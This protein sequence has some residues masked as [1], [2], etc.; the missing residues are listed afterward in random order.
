MKTNYLRKKIS[1]ESGQVLILGAI[2]SVVLAVASYMVLNIG[3][4]AS[5]KVSLQNTADAAALAGAQVQA[6][7]V[8]T[9]AWMNQAMGTI[10]FYMATHSANV[11]MAAT[12]MNFVHHMYNNRDADYDN[13]YN[14]SKNP[15]MYSS[16]GIEMSNGNGV[17]ETL[18]ENE[19][20]D[21]YKK[22]YL[23]AYTWIPRG[24]IWL[25]MMG[26]VQRGISYITPLMVEKEVFLAIQGKAERAAIFP[27]FKMYTDVANNF[28][29]TVKKVFENFSAQGIKTGWEFFGTP[30]DLSLTI[31]RDDVDANV[32]GNYDTNALTND[33]EIWSQHLRYRLRP[34]DP[35][36]WLNIDS[37]GKMPVPN[38]KISRYHLTSN[39][40]GWEDAYIQY[41]PD[42]VMVITGPNGVI[43]ITQ[44]PDGSTTIVDGSNPPL[45]YR[46]VGNTIETLGP[47]GWSSMGEID[48]SV[49][50]VSVRA[51]TD[52]SINLGPVTIVDP[53]TYHIG[54]TTI[55]VNEDDVR[56]STHIGRVWVRTES[57][58]AIISDLSTKTTDEKWRRRN[59]A[60]WT[61]TLHD[62]GGDTVRHRL[63]II[64]SDSDW[65]YEL[66]ETG[67]YV[68]EE[69]NYPHM[70][71]GRMTHKIGANF[72]MDR[73]G[74]AEEDKRW[75]ILDK[76]LTVSR[77]EYSNT[78][79]GFGQ[80]Y[81]SGP[82]EFDAS[83]DVRDIKLESFHIVAQCWN[84][85]CI[86]SGQ[87]G[88]MVYEYES[89]DDT[90]V[91]LP[92]ANNV[93]FTTL[94]M[95]R[96]CYDNQRTRN[97]DRRYYKFGEA[98]SGGSIWYPDSV[99]T[100]SGTTSLGTM[101]NNSYGRIVLWTDYDGNP[102]KGAVDYWKRTDSK[103]NSKSTDSTTAPD[104]RIEPQ[105]LFYSVIDEEHFLPKYIRDSISGSPSAS[106][107]KAALDSIGAGGIGWDM[108]H[109]QDG[110][111][112]I[113]MYPSDALENARDIASWLHDPDHGS[114][115]VVVKPLIRLDIT[116]PPPL[117]LSEDYFKFGVNVAVT[118]DKFDESKETKMLGVIKNTDGKNETLHGI[119]K[120]SW[121]MI[122]I[123]SART[124]F[125]YDGDGEGAYVFNPGDID[126]AQDIS[127][128]TDYAEF[129]NN[130][131]LGLDGSIEFAYDDSVSF[132]EATEYR[133]RRQFFIKRHS[134]NL[135]NSDWIAKLVPIKF[136]V[137]KED[138]DLSESDN[139]D[140]PAR[141]VYYNLM[142]TEWRETYVKT[143]G[144]KP[145]EGMTLGKKGP[146][147][148][149]NDEDIEAVI[150]H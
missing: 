96:I 82:I 139:F 111:T 42:G 128:A 134:D 131:N 19:I 1:S 136:T 86:K 60:H 110:K 132:E 36:T 116:A 33:P 4:V 18:S 105:V 14:L 149:T 145:P 109:N 147:L 29:L 67:G 46:R 117:V 16:T 73:H 125:W 23:D 5:E 62:Q 137:K 50:G 20:V 97:R 24:E 26:K 138:L 10:Y 124:A 142:R 35:E 83:N 141:Y 150:T 126:W 89:I 58:E 84:E 119:D 121:G 44:N 21:Q 122:A 108:D 148:S 72:I 71:N 133:I 114:S 13:A 17:S 25:W 135:Y 34:E 140:T 39:I 66:R 32:P 59:G 28:D 104:P 115:G 55:H 53:N 8:S 45:T 102:K 7:A 94:E 49:D 11:S 144:Y 76:N 31:T 37:L 143:S 98:D 9:M 47:G 79:Y 101:I 52:F 54:N 78:W 93:K 80:N 120:A 3:R 118:N 38:E 64:K 40:P 22:I 15:V 77:G 30:G 106:K 99:I 63:L 70:G 103:G 95:C 112:D 2:F 81:S 43:S 27:K 68:Q 12:K 56:I 74:E 129:V 92:A 113:I 130:T 41:D 88:F 90:G 146:R 91:P 100:A 57:G 123:A 6:N 87:K 69:D 48:A 107:L 65:L 51:T 61:N 127:Y 85:E 75:G